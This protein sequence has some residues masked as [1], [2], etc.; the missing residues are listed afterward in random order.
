MLGYVSVWEI[1]QASVGLRSAMSMGYSVLSM[2]S[3]SAS[4]LKVISLQ[5]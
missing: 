1:S 2:S 5:A 4:T 3:Q